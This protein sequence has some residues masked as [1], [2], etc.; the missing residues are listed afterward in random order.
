MP[1]WQPGYTNGEPSKFTFTIPI[2]F[3]L[4]KESKQ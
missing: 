2:N 1:R 4:E 3:Q